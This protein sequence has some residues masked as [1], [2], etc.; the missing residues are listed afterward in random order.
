MLMISNHKQYF[1]SARYT[2]IPDGAQHVIPTTTRPLARRSY[3]VNRRVLHLVISRSVSSATPS[4]YP[5]G[6]TNG[7][8]TSHQSAELTSLFHKSLSL[9]CYI[10]HCEHIV[11]PFSGLYEGSFHDLVPYCLQERDRRQ[12]IRGPGHYIV[13]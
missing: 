9:I 5:L 10:P 7:V 11:F 8:P 1:K 6:L 2:G 13:V 12:S 3:I 4:S